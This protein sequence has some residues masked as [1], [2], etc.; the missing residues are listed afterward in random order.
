MNIT[1]NRFQ[2]LDSGTF[3][4]MTVNDVT[5]YT[6]EK[7]WEN[8]EPFNS[9]VPSGVYSLIPHKSSKY[10]KQGKDGKVLCLVNETVTQFQEP[11]S[12]RYACLIHVANYSREV[13]GCI[14]L[15][16]RYNDGMVTNSRQSI[17]DFYS[18]VNPNETHTL[19]INWSE[20]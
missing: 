14:G 20:R 9:C 5:Y 15:G 12:K 2:S 17:K 13:E 3:G 19:T 10:G 1:L 18:L 7:P 11:H 8:N 16:N 6:V 4:K